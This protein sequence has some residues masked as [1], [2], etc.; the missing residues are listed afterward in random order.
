V[1]LANLTP[2]FS[3]ADIANICNEAALL[4]ARHDKTAVD[5]SDL[6]AA[7]DRCSPISL[8]ALSLS[9]SHYATLLSPLSS[10]F[11]QL[12]Y[13]SSAHVVGLQGGGW[14]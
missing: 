9:P 2:G 12:G 1:K 6:E 4:A 11:W 3:G 13:L 10:A 7:I 14:H 8:S 5:F